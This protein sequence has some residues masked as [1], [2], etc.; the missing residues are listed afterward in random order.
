MGV[1]ELLSQQV[2]REGND[3]FSLLFNDDPKKLN[4]IQG[5]TEVEPAQ[6]T[7]FATL[8]VAADRW[9]LKVPNAFSFH[10]YILN[11]S[12]DRKSRIEAVEMVHATQVQ[13]LEEE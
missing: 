3:L 10:V 7:E 9:N 13:R 8:R 12:K 2:G 6:V 11:N 4:R 1:L 5:A